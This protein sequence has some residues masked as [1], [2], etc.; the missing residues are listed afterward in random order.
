MPLGRWVC[1]LR[2]FLSG[3]GRAVDCQHY[4]GF[5]YSDRDATHSPSTGHF[6]PIHICLGLQGSGIHQSRLHCFKKRSATAPRSQ[7]P[8]PFF[9]CRVC[10]NPRTKKKKLHVCA[11]GG[12]KATAPSR[13]TLQ[14]RPYGRG[15]QG[16][17]QGDGQAKGR[18][19]EGLLYEKTLWNTP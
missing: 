16:P 6:W 4:F 8:S 19:S 15:S 14:T 11:S 17:G 10:C 5:G 2:P 18:L 9:N 7:P 1:G 3:F 13:Q 12:Q